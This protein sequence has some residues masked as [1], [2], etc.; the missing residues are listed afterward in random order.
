MV[1]GIGYEARDICGYLVSD[2]KPFGSPKPV[3]GLEVLDLI[4]AEDGDYVMDYVPQVL[5]DACNG[6]LCACA[7]HTRDLGVRSGKIKVYYL[8]FHVSGFQ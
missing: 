6:K 8:R 3:V 2:S 5:L 1:D 7:M 4:S